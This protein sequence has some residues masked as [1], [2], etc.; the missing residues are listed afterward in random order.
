MIEV[1]KLLESEEALL[2][3][4]QSPYLRSHPLSRERIAVVER[5]VNESRFVDTPTSPELIEGFLRIRAKL[6]G[7]LG[8]PLY[9]SPA[10]SYPPRPR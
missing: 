9:Q 8:R 5:A 3:T 4:S 2:S 10:Q 6:Q 7:Y 1:L